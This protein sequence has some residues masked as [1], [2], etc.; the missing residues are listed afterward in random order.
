MLKIGFFGSRNAGHPGPAWRIIIPLALAALGFTSTI[1]QLLLVRELVSVFYGNEL[2]LGLILAAWMLWVAL[3]AGIP[4]GRLVRWSIDH[5]VWPLTLV[6]GLTVV[7]LPAQMALIRRLPALLAPAS[8]VQVALGPAALATVI[9]L[10]PLCITLG[11]QFA[12]GAHWLRV[13]GG[14]VTWA[15]LYESLGAVVGGTLFS[16]GL[17]RWLDP[18]QVA[19]LVGLVNLT[20][21][22]VLG[23]VQSSRKYGAVILLIFSLLLLLIFPLGHGLHWMTLRAQYGPDLV[24]AAD[25]PY[26]RLAVLARA[27]QHIF[28][29][30]GLLSFETQSTHPAEMVHLS[31]LA[32]ASPQRVLLVGGVVAGNLREVLKHPVTRVV[33]VELDA[34]MLEAAREVLVPAALEPLDDPRVTLMLDDGRRYV[35]ASASRWVSSPT[36]TLAASVGGPSLR[37]WANTGEFFDVIILD[38]PP[39]ATGALNRYYTLTF[40]EHVQA[41]LTPGGLVAL[42]LPSAENYWSPALAQRN[43]SVYHTLRQVFPYVMVLPGEMDLYLA[44]QQPLTADVEIWQARFMARE[45]GAEG[46]LDWVT[47]TY[48]A[49]VLTGDRFAQVQR[50]LASATDVRLNRDLVPICYYYELRVWLSR[51]YSQLGGLFERVALVQLWWLLVPFLAWLGLARWRP[52]FAPV[53]VVGAAGFA[54]MVM[55]LA[56]LLG[57]QAQHGTLY[58]AVGIMVAAFMGGHTLGV[59][60]GGRLAG[61]AKRAL[62]L[63]LLAGALGAGVLAWL[64]TLSLS[65]PLFVLLAVLTG[66]VAGAVH[67]GTLQPLTLTRGDREAVR[68]A[69]RLYAADLLGGCLGALTGG[70]ILV[71]LL[72][73]PQSCI[74]VA[75]ALLTGALAMV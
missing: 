40:F 30:N 28:Y 17:V 26:G 39:P 5:G 21:G 51:F 58:Q 59:W 44:S 34:R 13:A 68:A 8:G 48:L 9:V 56:L 1:A 32:H 55:N 54:G 50:A 65:R 43:A 10:M 75:L 19:L 53:F 70:V 22:T 42:G 74:A 29:E 31:M 4:G 66:S 45:L 16:L 3:G 15:Y 25:S 49:Y 6:M 37:L 27:G 71:P 46:G 64:L 24:Y 14:Q 7:L 11:A 69:R 23:L 60:V 41:R 52:T 67:P 2:L 12:L 47:P 33:A 63:I 38:V 61:R 72:G 20:I 57:F 18:F 36:D 35:Q 62:L 73:V